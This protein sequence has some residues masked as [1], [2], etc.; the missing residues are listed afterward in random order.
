MEI[1][2]EYKFFIMNNILP[3]KKHPHS[4]DSP[5]KRPVNNRENH[6]GGDQIVYKKHST[7]H[8]IDTGKKRSNSGSNRESFRKKNGEFS[9]FFEKSFSSLKKM[10]VEILCIGCKNSSFQRMSEKKTYQIARINPENSCKI[11]GS[12]IDKSALRENGGGEENIIP[13]KNERYWEKSGK[14][15]PPCDAWIDE[16]GM[17]FKKNFDNIHITGILFG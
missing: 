5:I 1:Y 3:S 7:I 10:G 4:S 6:N 9:I 17:G 2:R 16:L 8:P 13:I 15:H 11:N 12:D 14:K